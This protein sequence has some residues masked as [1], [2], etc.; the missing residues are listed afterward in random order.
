MRPVPNI[1]QYDSVFIEME[2]VHPTCFQ[3]RRK[4]NSEIASGSV[5]R[6]EVSCEVN[7]TARITSSNLHQLDVYGRSPSGPVVPFGKE[8]AGH[9]GQVADQSEPVLDGCGIG[10]QPGVIDI[11]L[12]NGDGRIEMAQVCA[13]EFPERRVEIAIG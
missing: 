8:V 6:G 5:W 2:L 1:G 4:T 3:V 7:C 10:D 9:A 12:V 13:V 11:A